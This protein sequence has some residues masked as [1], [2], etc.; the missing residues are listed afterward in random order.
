MRSVTTSLVPRA[1]RAWLGAL[2][3]VACGA[4]EAP[5]A[6]QLTAPKVA[7]GPRISIPEREKDFGTLVQGDGATYDFAFESAG[8]APLI[9]ERVE[10]NCGCTVSE[11]LLGDLPYEFGRQI[12][13]GGKGVIRA[14]VRT[15]ALHG[16]TLTKNMKVVSND[17]GGPI[18]LQLHAEIEPYFLF[19]RDPP[20]LD[21]G[22]IPLGQAK[23]LA[24]V[25]RCEKVPAFHLGDHGTLPASLALSWEP[26]EEGKEDAWKIAVTLGADA[27]EG[28]LD[29]QI[30]VQ[31]DAG[32]SFEFY[33]IGSVIGPLEFLPAASLTFGALPQGAKSSRS[34]E[35]VVRDGEPPAHVTEATLEV[36]KKGNAQRNLREF[37]DV[38]LRTI[39]EGKRYSVEVVAL[40]TLPR[41][42]F[43]GTLHIATD[44]PAVPRRDVALSGS[45]R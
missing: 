13:P 27:T 3:L 21:F 5:L 19:D 34:I 33:V 42:V 16:G 43:A 4:L 41:G 10:V 22:S 24:L 23:T 32:R 15:G 25:V 9:I 17:P 14:H 28:K 11:V 6:A 7:P 44:H 40:E 45:V 35:I 26:V 8:D 2:L 39:E 18:V 12:P 38:Q 29:R 37:F 20:T 1:P 30:T 36:Q 31:T